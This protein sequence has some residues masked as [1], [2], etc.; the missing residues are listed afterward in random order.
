MEPP[1]A[2]GAAGALLRPGTSTEAVFVDAPPVADTLP[3]EG[4]QHFGEVNVASRSVT[5][6]LRDLDGAVLWSIALPAAR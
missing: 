5:V 6:D 1:A 3:M 2:A 4:Y